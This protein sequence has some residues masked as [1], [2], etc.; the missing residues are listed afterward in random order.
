VRRP[1]ETI[2][3]GYF[4]ITCWVDPLDSFPEECCLSVLNE[5]ASGTRQ[6]YR[7]ALRDINGDSPF[8][9]PPLNVDEV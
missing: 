7:G 5:G 1:V 4:Q 8:N 2:V 3:Y 9:Q 6:Y